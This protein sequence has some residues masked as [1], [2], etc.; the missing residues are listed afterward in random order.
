MSELISE[1]L[2]VLRRS[3]STSLLAPVGDCVHYAMDQ[4]GDAPL[5]IR[6]TE[7]AVEILAGDDVRRRL[8]P[9]C[10]NLHIS[11]LENDST[12]VISDRGGSQLPCDLV[13]GSL[14]PS[15]LAEK[16]FGNSIPVRCCTGS[17]LFSSSLVLRSTVKRPI[18]FPRYVLLTARPKHKILGCDR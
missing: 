16:Y 9:V 4:V 3:G 18:C 12:F 15:S 17:D 2:S 8:R 11:L 14:S 5:A 6:R 7:L 13:V 1:V 10:G